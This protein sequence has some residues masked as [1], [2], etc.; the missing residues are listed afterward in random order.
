VHMLTA[1]KPFISPAMFVDRNFVAGMLI[2]F[3]VGLVLLS[4]A[5]LLPGYLQ[6][7][8]GYSVTEAGLLMAP[9]GIGTMVAM[10]IAGRLSGRIDARLLMLFGI[11]TMA[12]TLWLMTGWTPDV[13]RTDLIWIT[14]LQGFGM[15]FVFIPLQVVAFATLPGQFRTDGASLFA[16]MRNMGSAIG[17]SIATWLLSVS[18]ATMYSQLGENVTPFNQAY[19]IGAAGLFYNPNIP[20]GL[21]GISA[22]ISRQAEIIAYSNDFMF[23]FWVSIPAAFALL[24]MR[25]PAPHKPTPEEAALAME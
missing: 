20:M 19:H 7:L 2:M 6:R 16:L 11:S 17:I 22:E 25:K 5:A 9:R 8:G 13:S 14:T 18:T 23:L 1:K 3:T 10:L 21:A 24:L 12:F 15:G 4:S